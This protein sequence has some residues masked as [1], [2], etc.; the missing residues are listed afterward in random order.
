[1]EHLNLAGEEAYDHD[2][3]KC[4]TAACVWKDALD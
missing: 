1:M 2:K 3:W 4:L